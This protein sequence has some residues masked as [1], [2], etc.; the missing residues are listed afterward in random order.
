[1]VGKRPQ[2]SLLVAAEPYRLATQPADNV[3]VSW[4]LV[5]ASASP[6]R[7]RLLHSAGLNP[8]VSVSGV[9]EPAHVSG[10]PNQSPGV[11]AQELARAKADKVARPLIERDDRSIVIGADSVLDV[12]GEPQGKPASIAAA[13]QRLQ[14]L[15]GRSAT[16]RTGH[17][18]IRTDTGAMAL[19]TVA[20][21]VRFGHWTEAELDW[22]LSTEESLEVAGAFTLDG[23]SAPFVAGVVGDP[24]N[25]IGLSLP[26]V[27]RLLGQLDLS[28][29]DIASHAQQ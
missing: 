12:D 3:T 2:G 17:C 4:P 14:S 11:I 28:W 25:V 18:L 10:L 29:V 21:E 15:Q 22:Y 1:M 27:R 9:D 13:R 5:L 24:G 7:L 26:E 20:T 6:A 23:L 8:T 16:L 19:G